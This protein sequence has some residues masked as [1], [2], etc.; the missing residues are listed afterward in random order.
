M[1]LKINRDH[2]LGITLATRSVPTKSANPLFVN[3]LLE[4]NEKG[5]TMLGS[6]GDLTI[7]T[8]IPIRVNEL[9]FFEFILKEKHCKR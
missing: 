6:S 4:A 3:V 1:K 7:K 2:L 9:E 8:L 5:L